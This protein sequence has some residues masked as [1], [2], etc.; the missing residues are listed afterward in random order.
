MKSKEKDVD[1][2]VDPNYRCPEPKNS[3]T[4]GR[5]PAEVETGY[6]A[7]E[8]VNKHTEKSSID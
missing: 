1:E 4:V 2:V 3:T 5:S 8:S 6:T 7:T